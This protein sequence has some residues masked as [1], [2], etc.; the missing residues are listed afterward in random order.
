MLNSGNDPDSLGMT[1]MD[2]ISIYKRDSS[3]LETKLM[4]QSW[5]GLDMCR[6]GYIRYSMLN[7]ELL[8]R[9]KSHEMPDVIKL[10]SRTAECWGA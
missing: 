9:V 2:K 5:N 8:G 10:Q 3:G 6:R 7:I 1:S 4:R